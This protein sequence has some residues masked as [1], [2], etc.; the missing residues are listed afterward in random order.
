MTRPSLSN[1]LNGSP[2]QAALRR[3]ALWWATVLC[4]RPDAPDPWALGDQDDEVA[5]AFLQEV[6]SH[7]PWISR[8][9]VPELPKSCWRRVTAGSSSCFISTAGA[10]LPGPVGPLVV[11]SSDYSDGLLIQSETA[12]A[13]RSTANRSRR[14]P[15]VK[16]QRASLTS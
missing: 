14:E 9:S 5:A 16:T 4:D 13:A 8:M 3:R 1:G 6:A 2:G 12:W 10:L 11:V 15:T 7:L